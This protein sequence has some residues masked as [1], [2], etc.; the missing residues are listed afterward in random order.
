MAE[1]LGEPPSTVQSW[2]L[3]GRIPAAKQPAVL[4]KARELGLPVAAED[5]IFPLGRGQPNMETDDG[6]VVICDVC[7]RP[8]GA[9][10]P[11]ACTFIDCPHAR[12]SMNM[13]MA[14]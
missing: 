14:A 8:V 12:R 5:I 10:T 6:R 4:A 1:H 2:K 3:V 9:D 13:G 11:A 7:E